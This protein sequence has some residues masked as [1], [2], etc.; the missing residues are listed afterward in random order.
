MR[1]SETIQ[2]NQIK[3]LFSVLTATT[4][5]DK[6]TIILWAVVV[7]NSDWTKDLLTC[8]FTDHNLSYSYIC[9]K[10]Q[11]D[12]QTTVNCFCEILCF[13]AYWV[14]IHI[15]TSLH[16]YISLAD[17]GGLS[18]IYLYLTILLWY[19]HVWGCNRFA[20]EIMHCGTSHAVQYLDCLDNLLVDI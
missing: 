18:K 19:V 13:T 6:Y 20:N 12:L 11:K 1:Y 7:S 17:T 4:I 2:I 10:R 5:K 3:Y 14:N 15:T 16:H 9:W 8:T